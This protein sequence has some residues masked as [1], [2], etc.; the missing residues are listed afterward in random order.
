MGNEQSTFASDPH[1]LGVGATLNL[2]TTKV[3]RE[4]VQP[5]ICSKSFLGSSQHSLHFMDS[6]RFSVALSISCF[7]RRLFSVVCLVKP[8]RYLIANNNNEFFDGLPSFVVEDKLGLL[9][10]SFVSH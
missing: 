7:F 3:C 4:L 10:D 6:K 8:C 1:H 9:G 2:C 5:K